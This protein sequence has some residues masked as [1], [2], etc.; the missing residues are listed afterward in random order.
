MMNINGYNNQF[1]NVRYNNSITNGTSGEN[2]SVDNNASGI[3]N[4]FS[5]NNHERVIKRAYKLDELRNKGLSDAD[6][7]K[8]FTHSSGVATD[9]DDRSKQY[10]FSHYTLNSKT[11]N[12]VEYK[13]E[14]EAIDA[15]LNISTKENNTKNLENFLNDVETDL[16][17]NQV[18]IIKRAYNLEELKNKGLSDA[19]IAKYFKHSKGVATDYDDRSKQNEFSHY[20][21]IS[22]TIDGIEYKTEE[23]AI[24]AIL[25]KSKNGQEGSKPTGSQ[26][27]ES[28]NGKDVIRPFT[29][30]DSDSKPVT[31]MELDP[32]YSTPRE[33][34]MTK[35]EVLG[36]F[37][38]REL[39]K[40]FDYNYVIKDRGDNRQDIFLAYIIKG[41]VII[42]GVKINTV[43]EL[44]EALGK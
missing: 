20:T 24:Q 14:E 39:A 26:Q 3:R 29:N 27:T 33:T 22:K 40:Y 5:N 31:R 36:V 7:A 17:N 21:L 38:Q 37:S 41:N 35:D 1:S 19:D 10:E 28:G 25:N 32:N 2:T 11:I 18:R 9:Y 16:I 8:Y 43:E 42:D 23:E 15:I 6:I 44:K 13:T 30:D 34:Y 12:G 4:D